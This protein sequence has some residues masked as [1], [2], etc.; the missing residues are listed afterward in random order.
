MSTITVLSENPC[1]LGS[2]VQKA[3]DTMRVPQDIETKTI[4]DRR[5]AIGFVGSL[6]STGKQLAILKGGTRS[7]SS[8]SSHG[9][10]A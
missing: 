1:D 8:T 6:V 2:L 10:S 9:P 5:A 4:L 7:G 3:L